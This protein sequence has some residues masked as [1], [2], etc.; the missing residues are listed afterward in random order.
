MENA[1]MFIFA[2]P[3]GLAMMYLM[4]YMISLVK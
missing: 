4:V 3:I 2:L 1:I